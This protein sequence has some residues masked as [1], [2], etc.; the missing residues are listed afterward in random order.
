MS[1]VRLRGALERG[2]GL[3][4]EV[5]NSLVDEYGMKMGQR[6]MHQKYGEGVIMQFEGSGVRAKIEV[7]FPIAGSKWLMVAY[8]NLETLD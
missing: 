2:V 5:S 3:K 7:N 4:E 6:V 8:A 1:E